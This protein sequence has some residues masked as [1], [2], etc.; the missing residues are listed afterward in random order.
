M[1][2]QEDALTAASKK[3]PSRRQRVR[4]IFPDRRAEQRAGPDR[5]QG[6]GRR[7]TDKA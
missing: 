7:K 6:P 3:Q 4:R 5:R 1:V 2:M